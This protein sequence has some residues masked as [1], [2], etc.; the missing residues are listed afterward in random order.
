MVLL[1][2][3]QSYYRDY[4]EPVCQAS[5]DPQ[6]KCPNIVEDGGGFEGERYRCKVCGYSY[7]L[8]Y[9]DMK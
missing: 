1:L 8:D 5:F 3:N 9:E 7:F 4:K 2:V 6:W